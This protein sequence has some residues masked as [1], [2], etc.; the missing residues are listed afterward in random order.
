MECW[1]TTGG[2]SPVKLGKTSVVEGWTVRPRVT[3]LRLGGKTE[4]YAKPPLGLLAGN[5]WIVLCQR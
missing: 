2:S 4:A 3:H 5:A 1:A